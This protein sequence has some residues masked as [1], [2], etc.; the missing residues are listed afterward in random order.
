M[1]VARLRTLCRLTG[2]RRLLLFFLLRQAP[3]EVSL[4]DNAWRSKARRPAPREN[5]RRGNA[6][7]NPNCNRGA[8][9]TT[10]AQPGGTPSPP[11]CALRGRTVSQRGSDQ[12]L[13]DGC[14]WQLGAK[15]QPERA[16]VK[17][18]TR[19][20]THAGPG[21]SAPGLRTRLQP[22]KCARG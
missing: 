8:Q 21:T 16:G 14:S 20:A 22:E 12:R 11:P 13:E 17:A 6:K 15:S 1:F 5:Q 9:R 18:R 7:M 2:C 4:K 19:L 10:A 3:E